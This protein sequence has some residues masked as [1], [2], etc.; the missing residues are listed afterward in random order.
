MDLGLAGTR[1]II[2]GAS[3]GIGAATAERLAA[4]GASLAL[5]ARTASQLEAT[6]SRI[7]AEHGVEVHP[8]AG[9]LSTPTG[10]TTAADAAIGALG[11]LDVLINN[12]GASP[13]GTFDQLDDDAWHGAFDLKLMGYVR[14]MRAA[15][16]PMRA[17]RKGVIINVGGAAARQA[18]PGY[19][20]GCFN[21]AIAHLTRTTAE[22][23]AVDGIR[24]VCL[25][26]GPTETERYTG[27]LQVAADRT[28]TPLETVRER[29]AASVPI[30]RLGDPDE[31][32]SMLTILCSDA[33][34][35]MTGE[36][37]LVDGGAAI[38]S[39]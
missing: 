35:L 5:I 32:A 27:M 7:S 22:H 20:L 19:V 21:I 1:C 16:V 3:K 39:V 38:G 36:S 6:A 25:H 12:A 14:M 4:E 13:A 17:N 2:T 15:L 23:V 31:V 18:S 8:I 33:A 29:A 10:A 28:C 24:A 9:D 26:P 34:S 37:F 30:G 11:G